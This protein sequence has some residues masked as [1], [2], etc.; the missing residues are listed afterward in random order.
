MTHYPVAGKTILAAAKSRYNVIMING[1]P[2]ERRHH[3]RSASAAALTLQHGPS[4]REFPARCLDI[5]AG[6]VLAAVPA[7]MP[8]RVGHKVRVGARE[9]APAPL[10]EAAQPAV[11]VRVERSRLLKDGVLAI[12]MRFA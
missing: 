11:V 3:P 6:G 4:G 5:S 8:V 2:T 1:V 7:A 10:V 12:A 9:D